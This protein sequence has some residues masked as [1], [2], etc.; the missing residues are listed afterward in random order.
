MFELNLVNAA[1]VIGAGSVAAVS[2]YAYKRNQAN[3]AS[4]QRIK[5]IRDLREQIE[6]QTDEIAAETET[7][8]IITHRLQDNNAKLAELYPAIRRNHSA[9]N[10]S[11]QPIVGDV[12]T[13]NIHIGTRGSNFGAQITT[14][15]DQIEQ[16]LEEQTAENNIIDN[17][18]VEAASRVIKQQDKIIEK[19]QN[20]DVSTNNLAPT[21]T[22]GF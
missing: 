9:E 22:T 18:L 14:A 17:A 21:Q 5:Q 10:H 12:E 7:M 3:S 13:L 16:S 1:L 2:V 8:A 4:E 6:K 19:L 11:N 15:R 20:A